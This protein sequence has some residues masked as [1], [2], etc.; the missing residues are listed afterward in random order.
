MLRVN[1]ALS[2]QL[3]KHISVPACLSGLFDFFLFIFT[4]ENS[5]DAIG[6]LCPELQNKSL[7]STKLSVFI[8]KSKG[9]GLPI[10]ANTAF[11]Q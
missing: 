11:M 4:I 6:T 3:I 10:L 7:T 2:I 8:H 9:I 5:T 1:V